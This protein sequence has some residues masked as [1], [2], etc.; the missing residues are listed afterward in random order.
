MREQYACITTERMRD[1]S[2]RLPSSMTEGCATGPGGFFKW[3]GMS[4]FVKSVLTSAWVIHVSR[5]SVWV[6]D[7]EVV[8]AASVNVV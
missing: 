5:A 8:R 6:E 1:M 3:R 7:I 2:A 4:S